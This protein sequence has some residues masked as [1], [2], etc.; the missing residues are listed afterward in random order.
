MSKS[1]ILTHEEISLKLDRIAWQILEHHYG[2]KNIVLV[3]LVDR[4]SEVAEKIKTRL[5]KFGSTTIL[6]THLHLD[7]LAG[8]ASKVTIDDSTIITGN[9]IILVDDVL[10]SGITLAAALREVL[11]HSPK[12]VRTAVLANRD[13]HKFP[14]QANYV[15]VSLATTLQEN[16]SYEVTNGEM[17]VWLS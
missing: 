8:L 10:N 4:G 14:I 16:I 9:S 1:L 11:C 5:E 6:Y 2:E 13:H 7:K 17:S 12:S 15:G 3:G